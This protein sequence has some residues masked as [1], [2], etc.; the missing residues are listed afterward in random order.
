M[1][2]KV[3][4][5]GNSLGVR[6]PKKIADEVGLFPG[7]PIKVREEAGKIVIEQSTK[8]VP[9]IDLKKLLKGMKPG[10]Y[11]QEIDWGKPIGREI[12]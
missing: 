5:W 9:K 10:T 12:W 4:K 8:F 11:H 3:Q 1:T 2:T 6:I 7:R